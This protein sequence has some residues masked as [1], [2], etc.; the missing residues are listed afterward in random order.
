MTRVDIWRAL[1]LLRQGTPRK[2][3]ARDAHAAI[4]RILQEDA[5][6]DRRGADEF[7]RT[8]PGKVCSRVAPKDRRIWG[9]RARAR[10][11]ARIAKKS[12]RAVR[13]IVASIRVRAV[14]G[15]ICSENTS[16]PHCHCN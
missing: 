13:A 4:G 5:A 8:F 2:V 11:R 6:R 3:H 10:A 9:S 16:S 12:T 7:I 14:S 1:T 15:C